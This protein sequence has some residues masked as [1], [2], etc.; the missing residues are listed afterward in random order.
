MSWNLIE[1]TP[2]NWAEDTAALGP[3]EKN[4]SLETDQG[5]DEKEFLESKTKYA[6]TRIQLL[7]SPT[8][9]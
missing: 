3:I 8:A 9:M 7:A 4:V 5:G 6:Q 1:D 2:S